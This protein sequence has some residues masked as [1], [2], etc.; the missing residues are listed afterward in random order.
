MPRQIKFL[1]AKFFQKIGQ[2]KVKKGQKKSKIE[3][4]EKVQKHPFSNFLPKKIE[5]IFFTKKL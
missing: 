2:K 3:K 5:K 4:I 1:G